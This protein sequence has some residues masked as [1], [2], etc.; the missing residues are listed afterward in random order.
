MKG[1]IIT[2]FIG[3]ILFPLYSI[4]QIVSD[5]IIYKNKNIPNV[6]FDISYSGKYMYLNNGN[7][8]DYSG[9][10]IIAKLNRDFGIDMMGVFIR[11]VKSKY[12]RLYGG[13]GANFSE[14]QINRYINNNDQSTSGH[15]PM[16]YSYSP[17]FLNYKLSVFR[18]QLHLNHYTFYNKLILF[19]K[20]GIAYSYFIKKVNSNAQYIEIYGNSTPARDSSFVSSSNPEGWHFIDNYTYTTK[21]D[22]DIYKNGFSMFYK[23]GLGYR[24]KKITPF[25]NFEISYVS[26]KFW[27]P[28]LKGQIGINYSL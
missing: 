25:I 6:M 22:I 20:V 18:L 27:S 26:W 23:F 11:N 14:F 16:T 15:F 5:S 19:Q 17:D 24:I 9:G 2:I 21:N 7:Y 12:H 8:S 4:S 1:T 28:Y 3:I 10:Q 13:L